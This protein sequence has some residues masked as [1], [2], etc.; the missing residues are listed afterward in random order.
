MTSS[1]GQQERNQDATCY[2]GELDPKVN[3]ALLWEIFVQAGPV[4]NVHMPRDKLTQAH[5]GYGFVE[6]RSEEDADYAIKVMNMVKLY[7]KP[8]KVNKA[9]RDKKTLEVG[10]NLFIG[11]LDA[12][13]DEKLLYDTFSAFGVIIS[14]PKIVRDT[15]ST[16]PKG[17]GFVSYDCF[18]AS[19]LAIECMNG[20]FLCNKLISVTYAFKKDSKTE[21]HGDAA[22]RFL[23][24]QNPARSRPNTFFAANPGEQAPDPMQMQGMMQQYPGYPP[25]GYP[26]MAPPMAPPPPMQPPMG[27]MGQMGPPMMPGFPQPFPGMPFPPPGGFPPHPM[28]MPPQG[29]PFPYP[30][31]PR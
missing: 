5:N 25:Q 29:M 3:E 14:P 4:V 22:E 24:A 16:D 19:D 11:N 6:F 8:M 30:L 18:E 2:I 31:P 28:F 10:A 27:A 9:T 12:E 1:G 15:S 20:Q 7:G 23:A 26:P 13:V 17:Y 21:R